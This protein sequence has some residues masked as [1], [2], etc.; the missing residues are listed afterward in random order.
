MPNII[1]FKTPSEVPDADWTDMLAWHVPTDDENHVNFTSKL[2]HV[3]GEMASRLMETYRDIPAD[4]D[5]LAS[6]LAASILAGDLTLDD[7]PDN[8]DP[9]TVQDHVTQIGQGPIP[10]REKERLGPSDVGPIL[11]RKIYLREI[12][13]L[14]ES[15][16]LKE[17]SRPDDIRPTV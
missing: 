9:F 15:G 6:R 5:P 10:D 7:I 8:V 1:N 17:W 12:R 14:N 11:L 13:A 4:G 2:I 3:K 16:H